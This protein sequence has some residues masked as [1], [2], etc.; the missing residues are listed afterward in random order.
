ME[1]RQRLEDSPSHKTLGTASTE[2]FQSVQHK[3]LSKPTTL[4]RESLLFGKMHD[5]IQAH[6]HR[7]TLTPSYFCDFNYFFYLCYAMMFSKF[8]MV[9]F[10]A[11][12]VIQILAS[13]KLEQ[14]DPKFAFVTVVFAVKTIM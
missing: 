2:C 11:L 5:F 8:V 7:Y 1:T 4:K 6:T 13:L 14:K 9:R 3:L 12:P 10:K